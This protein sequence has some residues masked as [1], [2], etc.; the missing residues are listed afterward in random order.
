MQINRVTLTNFR[1][2]RN[3]DLELKSGPTLLH[4]N[5]AQGKTNFL[6]AIYYMAT[7]RSPQADR[8]RQLINW[9]ALAS[10]E[11]V[12][13]G[14]IVAQ[15]ETAQGLTDLEVRLIREFQNGKDGFRREALINKRKV[16]LMDFL[17]KLRIVL[18]LPQDIELVT[19][20]PS[21]RRRYIDI[22]LCQTDPV[23]CRALSDFKK[24]LEQRNALLRQIS[25]Q[26]YGLDVLPV[27]TEK[28]VDSGVQIFI[29]RAALLNSLDSIARLIHRSKLTANGES[30]GLRYFPRLDTINN[31]ASKESSDLSDWINK[32]E[33]Q[34]NVAGRFH[35]ELAKAQNAEIASGLTLVGPHRD[36]WR[37]WVDGK[38]LSS[39]GSRGQQRTALLALK[40]S[41]FQWMAEETGETPILLLDEVVAELD[42]TRRA[43]LLNTV[44]ETNQS[45]LTATDPD[46]FSEQFLISATTLEI[47]GGQIINKSSISGVAH[48]EW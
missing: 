5:N 15:I 21:K 29:K 8:G 31:A 6:E 19:G 30:L 22:T 33:S 13:V 43:L 27:Y 37:F 26:G 34:D 16:R 46:M 23:Y 42:K 39:Y 25:D 7:M 48:Q 28:L 35:E 45:I 32:Q 3:L 38:D 47:V 40:L 11:P 24:V 18:F 20:P 36:D 1:N 12:V 41:E 44:T 17:G 2:Y 10:G 14:R 9:V 4:G